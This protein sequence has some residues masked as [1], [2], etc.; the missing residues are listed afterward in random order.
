ML[1]F[2]FASFSAGFNAASWPTYSSMS[3]ETAFKPAKKYIK[4]HN[5]NIK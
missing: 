4:N 5:F 1:K 3:C 2:A